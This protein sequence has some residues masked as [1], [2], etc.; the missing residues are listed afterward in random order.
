MTDRYKSF[1]SDARYTV[2]LNPP[3]RYKADWYMAVDVPQGI[4]LES[5]RRFLT[6]HYGKY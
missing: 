5:V 1:R 2:E 4:S 3:T 6:A